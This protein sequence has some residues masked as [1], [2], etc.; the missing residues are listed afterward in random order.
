MQADRKR[1]GHRGFAERQLFRDRDR[2]RRVDRDM[3]A[4]TA[5]HMRHAH[6]AAH[7]AHVEALIAHALAAMDADAAGTARIDRDAR[8]RRKM[9][10]A[11]A[12]RGDDAGD[13]VPERHRLLDPHGA[14]AAVVIIMQVGTADAAGGDLDAHFAGGRRRIGKAVDPQVLRG[15]NDDC[16]HGFVLP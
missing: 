1:L 6:R 13:F 16:A 8:A 9:R 12:D 7:E 10:N 4:K 3:L 11:G 5:L 15:V 14:E 2:L